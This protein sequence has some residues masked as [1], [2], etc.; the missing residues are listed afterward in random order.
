MTSPFQGMSLEMQQ[1]M[2][3]HFM[4]AM[5]GGTAP[6]VPP[7]LQPAPPTVQPNI[8]T[9]STGVPQVS[10]GAIQP[11]P[12]AVHPV[13]PQVAANPVMVG[14]VQPPSL[15]IPTTNVHRNQAA[16]FLTRTVQPAQAGGSQN[17]VT[18]GT[19]ATN[20]QPNDGTSSGVTAGGSSSG[21]LENGEEGRD[22]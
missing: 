13:V 12:P 18:A 11:N 6:A 21:L 14:S 10:V 16:S 22:T 7:L 19:T 8:P 4:V 1:A 3:N 5:Q 15:T 9:G 2:F 20:Q 17:I